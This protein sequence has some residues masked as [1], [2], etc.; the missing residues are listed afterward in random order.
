MVRP[1][2]GEPVT[3]TEGWLEALTADRD[4]V[5]RESTASRVADALRHR[6]I[7]GELVPGTR[8]SEEGICAAL[9][10]S[11]NTLREA[12]RLLSHERLLEHVF[13]RG[14]FV[15]SP[16]SEDVRELYRFRRILEGAAIRYAAMAAEDTATAIVDLSPL[17]DAV[18]DGQR[19]SDRADWFGVG[20]AN[21]HFHQQLGALPGSARMDETMSHL[22][23]ELRLVFHAMADPH[24]FH[25]PYLP[26]NEHLLGLL[27][28][29]DYAAAEEYLM[30]YLDTAEGQLLER[31]G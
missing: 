2:K 25:A 8:L 18:A 13:N 29:G 20:T 22:L 27:E 11:R 19:A 24:A 17:R 21:I 7:E 9:G 15:R 10:V 23:A 1:T 14:V 4:L 6:V 3:T 26:Q 12:F 5:S 28:A 31:L 30:R 16:T